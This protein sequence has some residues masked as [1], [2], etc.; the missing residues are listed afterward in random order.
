[1]IYYTEEFT[2]QEKDIL[3][4]YFTNIEGPVFALVNLPEVVKGALFARYSRTSKSLRRLFLDEFVGDLDVI[5][6]DFTDANVGQKRA[7]ELYNKVFFA[8]GDD[9]VAQLGGVHLACESS[10]IILTKILEWGRLMGYLEQ[11]TR[12]IPYTDKLDGRFRYYRSK[13]ILRSK[14]GPEY[15]NSMDDIFEIYSYLIEK[16][17]KWAKKKYPKSPQDSDFVYKNT[18]NAKA[19]DALRGLLP[20]ATTSNLGIYGNGQVFE[21]LI[22]RMNASQ[23]PEAQEYAQMMLK[24]L[25]KVIP[26]FLT[27]V[28]K[29]DRGVVWA[30]YLRENKENTQ[31]LVRELFPDLAKNNED[32]TDIKLIDFDPKG[33]DKVVA[34][35]IFPEVSADETTVRQYVEK[36]SAAEKK[37][38]IKTYVGKRKNRRHKAGRAFEATDYRFD[39][40]SDYGAFRDLQRH[41]M[42]TI[43]WQDLSPNHGYEIPE[44]V[45]EAKA[46]KEYKKAMQISADIYE[47]LYKKHPVEA[48]YAVSL[49]Y[50]VRYMMQA[51]A[52][53]LTHMLE[54]RTTPQG[55]SS[56]RHVCQQMHNLIRDEAN[57]KMIADSM[58]YVDHTNYELERLEAERS[59]EKKKSAKSKK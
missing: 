33:E 39:I 23:L 55:H 56:Y 13:K 29:K 20:A 3:R 30:N 22:L 1:M 32:K 57:H 7:E 19:Y 58:K 43:E 54:L 42:L 12:Y 48:Q 17:T 9:S 38:I 45:L 36:L 51:N 34:A 4:R 53:A 16:L 35:I 31:N 50:R 10:S 21:Q 46:G 24:E 2:D 5:E 8:Y 28:D 41:R 18:I 49:G 26:S 25:R 14:L 40:L 52:R 44:D 15:I 11:S 59:A 37:K 47:K 6:D 27:R